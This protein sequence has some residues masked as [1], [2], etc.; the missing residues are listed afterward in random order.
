M[1]A[2]SRSCVTVAAAA[3]AALLGAVPVAAAT[4]WQE[5]APTPAPP[6]G[7]EPPPQGQ[8]PAPPPTQEPK[9]EP[10][11]PTKAAAEILRKRLGL[12]PGP[13]G[14]PPPGPIEKPPEPLPANGV[15]PTPPPAQGQ[16]P[17]GAQPQGGEPQEPKPA[18]QDPTKAAAEAIKRLLPNATRPGS[19]PIP[20]ASGTPEPLA[21]PSANDRAAPAD[22]APPARVDLPWSGTLST[23]YRYRH[24]GGVSDQDL[25]ARLTLDVGRAEDPLSVHLAARGFADLD[26][27][28]AD[29][30]FQGLDQSF[31]DTVQGRVYAAYANL[32]A[33]PHTDVFRIGRQDLDETPTPVSF[34]GLRVD[35]ERFGKAGVWGG[36]Y[37]GLPVHQFEASRHGDVVYGL[38]GGLAPWQGGRVRLDWMHLRDEWL[39]LE[40]T[41]D[42]LGVRWWQSF[43][44]VSL[45]GL[46]TWRDGKPRDLQVH[47]RGELDAATTVT[48][49]WSELLTTQRA[50]VTELDPFYE[51]ASDYLPYRQL[52]ASL[53]RELW[54]GL[55]ASLGADVRRLRDGGSAGVFNREF[56]R[57]F[58]DATWSGWGPEG[59]SLSV[60]GSQWDADSEGFRTVTGELQYRPDRTLRLA[61]GS[62]YDLFRYD[63]FEGRERVHVRSFYLHGE[64]Q[65]G[66]M[67]LDAGYDYERDDID[68]FHVFRLGV[69]WKF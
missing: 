20:T 51:I 61:L 32:H 57:Y 50:A 48:L 15:E 53:G 1:R 56:E 2:P 58:A 29:D 63:V 59:L 42:L 6:Q 34:D 54:T 62:G 67:R 46:H 16:E 31:G 5:P 65:L 22:H 12:K 38:A 27:R 10:I 43:G 19:A 21:G 41:D 17:Q 30:P 24:G 40:R 60:S 13:E 23:R 37:A 39:S 47:A 11:D 14:K 9:S 8:E 25:V 28:R 55:T 45:H 44:S 64:R 52:E 33:L 26:G 7:Q 4:R 49:G 66:A 3:A 36:L 35:T 68:E 18:V 69:T